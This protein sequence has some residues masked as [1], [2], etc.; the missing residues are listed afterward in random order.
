MRAGAKRS[1]TPPASGGAM[2][3]PTRQARAPFPGPL[4]R[5]IQN[6]PQPLSM[7]NPTNQSS[8]SPLTYNEPRLQV[9]DPSAFRSATYPTNQ[10]PAQS[11]QIN[12]PRVDDVNL[13]TD[14]SANQDQKDQLNQQSDLK[15]KAIQKNQV[16]MKKQT[17][18]DSNKGKIR[19]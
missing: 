15:A 19:S 5:P 7:N 13:M 8:Q 9:G 12:Q 11:S 3:W 6:N 1:F 18:V 17:M 4:V 2:N 10:S 16:D 14:I